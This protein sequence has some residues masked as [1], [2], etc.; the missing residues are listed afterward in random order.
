MLPAPW[1]GVLAGLLLAWMPDPQFPS[2][3]APLTLSLTHIIAVAMLLPV[4]IGALFQLFPVVAGQSIAAAKRIA[5]WVAI[6]CFSTALCLS[7]GFFYSSRIAFISAGVIALLLLGSTAIALFDAGRRMFPLLRVDASLA[8]LATISLPI[9]L[10]LLFALLMLSV[11]LSWL[12]I[13]FMALLQAHVVWALVGLLACLVGGVAATTVPMFWQTAR[14]SRAWSRFWPCPVFILCAFVTLASMFEQ[15]N[16]P[17][18]SVLSILCGVGLIYLSLM[19]K[20]LLGA[21]R[22]FDPAWPLWVASVL[23]WM[24]AA[25]LCMLYV[26]R[27]YLT[28]LFQ[29][30]LLPL[31]PSSLS[32]ESM[33]WMIGVLV[34]IGGAVL[35]MNAMIGKIVPFL[36]FLH[37]RRAIPMGQKIPSMQMIL[38][39][40]FLRYQ[41][42]LVLVS[43]CFAVLLPIAPSIL[44]WCAGL[45]FSASQALLAIVLMRC[46]LSYR[47]QIQINRSASTSAM[48]PSK[49]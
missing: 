11:L 35:P 43:L 20:N 32:W 10:L 37:V 30:P 8:T 5:P 36:V 28:S 46:L 19:L 14:P 45:S 12:Q 6:S 48:H 7:W 24:L 39:P 34:L 15:F 38:P 2:R 22:R 9:S 1:C 42:R 18:V 49:L 21:R 40:V 3:F 41:A 27:T 4:M 29:L 47:R 33:P 16:M 23:S 17:L 26:G 44:R 13:D 25:V 31:M